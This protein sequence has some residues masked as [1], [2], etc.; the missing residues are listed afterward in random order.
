VPRFGRYEDNVEKSRKVDMK[1]RVVAVAIGSGGGSGL[2]AVKKKEKG[3]PS[4][5]IPAQACPF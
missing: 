5:P 4:V 3:L 2:L 1:E